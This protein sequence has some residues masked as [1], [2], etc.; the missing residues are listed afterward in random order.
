MACATCVPHGCHCGNY[1]GF[2]PAVVDHIFLGNVFIHENGAW[3]WS[4]EALRA[5]QI[6]APNRHLLPC[7]IQLSNE[8][9]R[10]L[11]DELRTALRVV[12][13]QIAGESEDCS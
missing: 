8:D 2:G 10:R 9:L 7:R 1:D 4:K 5:W 12:E 13:R 3:Q 6:Y 11:R